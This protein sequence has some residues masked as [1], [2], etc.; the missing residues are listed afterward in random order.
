MNDAT[1]QGGEGAFATTRWTL[2]LGARGASPQAKAALGELC[3]A[4]WEPVFQ[5]I[6]RRAGTDDAARD[7][8]QEF[9]ARL[10]ARQ[11]LDTVRPG[12]GRFRSFLLGAVRHFLAD[13]HDHDQAAKRGGGWERMALD[14]GE[15]ETDHGGARGVVPVD[16]GSPVP[17]AWFDRDWAVH[18]V[19]RAVDALASEHGAAGRAG[20]FAVLKPWLLGE[21]AGLTQ[22]EAARQLGWTENAV[23]VAVHRMRRRFRDLVKAEIAQTVV[24]GNLVAEELR[25]LLTVL[26]TTGSDPGADA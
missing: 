7:L 24:D 15:A 25:Y 21:V 1:I 20:V 5:F 26:S 19:N 22:T 10:L 4:Y 18:V 11:G 6:R 16:P 3:V 13:M 2:V 8:T 12:R 9:F 14:T 17:D 23:R